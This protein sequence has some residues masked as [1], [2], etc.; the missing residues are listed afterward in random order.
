[1]KT[2]TTSIKWWG[3][4]PTLRAQHKERN[5]MTSLLESQSPATTAY[6]AG[7]LPNCG[8]HAMKYEIIEI[9][10]DLHH[11]LHNK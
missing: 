5:E 7:T 1:M 2:T 4:H 11:K 6:A 10:F 3:F 8:R 9:K